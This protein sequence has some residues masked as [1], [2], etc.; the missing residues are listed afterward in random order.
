MWIYFSNLLK[1]GGL[2]NYFGRSKMYA[3]RHLV[4]RSLSASTKAS[5]NV[6]FGDASQGLE[7]PHCVKPT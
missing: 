7:N 3:F 6:C 4:V 5:W 2:C 1:V